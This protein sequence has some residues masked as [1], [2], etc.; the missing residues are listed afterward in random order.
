MSIIS[1][2]K[3]KSRLIQVRLDPETKTELEQT[4]SEL[5]LTTSQA[6]LIYIKQIILK[7]SI[8][9]N[10]SLKENNNE[11]ENFQK[12]QAKIVSKFDKNEIIPDFSEK[13]ARPFVS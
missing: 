7:K 8:P 3:K 9:F 6:L 13:N 11:Q 5:G 12:L 2:T 4:L 1:K 10:L